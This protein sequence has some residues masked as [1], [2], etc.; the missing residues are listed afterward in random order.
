MNSALI[1]VVGILSIL[2]GIFAFFDPLAATISAEQL[3]AW[4]F[5]FV[6]FMEVFS[7][8]RVKHVKGIFWTLVSSAII[9]LLIGGF[10]LFWPVQG[11]Y[12]LT[13]ALAVLFLVSGIVKLAYSFMLRGENY[14]W[15]HVI[16]GLISIALAALIFGYFPESAASILG[17]LLS[18]ELLFSGAS[19]VM[20]SLFF[21]KQEKLAE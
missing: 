12:T 14:F 16:S 11:I 1:F 19:L 8:V 4:L 7:A 10:L 17:I 21:K 2:A 5:L 3:A 6:G 9:A 13:I 20:V 15:M 18:V